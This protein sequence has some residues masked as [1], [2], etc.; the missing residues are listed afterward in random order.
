M[1]SPEEIA[2]A[3]KYQGEA[4]K[5]ISEAWEYLQRLGPEARV[6][7][8]RG[9]VEELAASADLLLSWCREYLDRTL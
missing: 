4:V 9:V 3:L 2:D 7:A 5:E 6:S 1:A 8:V